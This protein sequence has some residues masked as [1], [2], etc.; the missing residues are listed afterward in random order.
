[1]SG[2][3]DSSN[4]SKQSATS[5]NA[6]ILEEYKEV[7]NNMRHFSN[8]RVAVLT[9]VLAINGVLL[10][11]FATIDNLFSKLSIFT[12]GVISSFVFL[13][14]EK[15]VTTYYLHYQSRAKEL[16][17]QL[18]FSQY[19]TQPPRSRINATFVTRLL[20]WTFI[21]IW[22]LWLLKEISSR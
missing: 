2:N 8:M 17:T 19:L 3:T 10:E 5:N 6:Y 22:L 18:Q 13:I 12:I 16:E 11:K 21:L 14:F 9:I 4:S 1:M 15:R 7:G 20:Y